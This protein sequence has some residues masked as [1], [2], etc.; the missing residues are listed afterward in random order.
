MIFRKLFARPSKQARIAGIEF[1][2]S[3][4]WMQLNHSSSD[5]PLACWIAQEFLELFDKMNLVLRHTNPH[6]L[7]EQFATKPDDPARVSLGEVCL[8]IRL[9]VRKGGRS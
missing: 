1:F 2:A 6:M 4:G 3:S 9:C 7:T 5:D 8:N